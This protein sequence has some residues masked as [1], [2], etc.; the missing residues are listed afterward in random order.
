ITDSPETLEKSPGKEHV[1]FGN[2]VR[3]FNLSDKEAASQAFTLLVNSELIRSERRAKLQNA[4]EGFC[5]HHEERFWAE[6]NI[7]VSSEVTAKK[8]GVK[9]QR[10][11]IKQSE[12]AYN[13]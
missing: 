13:R 11:G 3:H 8:A 9:S 5:L 6:R 4:F 2:F 12:I 1:S 10:V 7:Q